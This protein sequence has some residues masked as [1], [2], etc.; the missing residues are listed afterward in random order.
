[1]FHQ[2][3]R[4]NSERDLAEKKQYEEWVKQFNKLFNEFLQNIRIIMNSMSVSEKYVN[5]SNQYELLT[6][7]CYYSTC[8]FRTFKI[9]E[10]CILSL[11]P[12]KENIA[13]LY[14]IHGLSS[15]IF[16][17]MR[18]SININIIP[19]SSSEY[20]D[21]ARIATNNSMM[22]EKLKKGETLTD[23]ELPNVEPPNDCCCVIC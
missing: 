19:P 11:E 15:A 16:K 14:K 21:I 18:R 12:T 7:R 8:L 20:S 5:V 2:S 23:V 4:I 9:V 10:I 22:L 1:M 3:G 6:R 13:I 17:H